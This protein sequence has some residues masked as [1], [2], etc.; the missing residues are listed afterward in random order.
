LA[1]WR[2]LDASRDMS[3]GALNRHGYR[4]ADGMRVI[5]MD[6]DLRLIG[7]GRAT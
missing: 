7:A 4:D 5:A 6:C 1:L 3:T 2:P